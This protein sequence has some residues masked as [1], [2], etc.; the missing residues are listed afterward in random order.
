MN[1]FI[2]LLS[3][4]QIQGKIR[5]TRGYTYAGTETG[6]AK[7]AI[8]LADAVPGREDRGAP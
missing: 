8:R 3:Y 7:S 2:I 4:A 5:R 6:T 1:K